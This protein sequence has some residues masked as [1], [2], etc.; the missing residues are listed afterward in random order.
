[1]RGEQKVINELSAQMRLDINRYKPIH[2]EGLVLYPIRVANYSEYM[3][4]RQAIGFMNQSLPIEYISMP[5]LSAFY[6]IDFEHALK[7]EPPTGLFASAMLGI[8]LA[9]RLNR[10]GESIDDTLQRIKVVADSRDQSRLLCIICTVNEVEEKTITPIQYASLR[11]IIAAQNGIIIRDEMDNPELVEAEADLAEANAPKLDYKIENLIHAA[12]ALTGKDEEEIYEWPVLKLA[13]RLST[14]KR[15]MDY[16]VCGI[17]EA[18]GTKWKSGNPCPHPW[19]DK[20]KEESSAL[21]SMDGFM[22]GAGLQAMKEAG[23]FKE[24]GSENTPQQK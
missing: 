9:L 10:D 22:G 11:P 13:N 16:V 14:F 21:I 24:R 12:A 18:Q 1:M 17:G 7:G 3:I 19:F 2:T 15:M 20:K 5:L 4:A 6:R 8:A 23:A